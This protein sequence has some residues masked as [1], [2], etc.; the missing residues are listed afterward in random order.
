MRYAFIFALTTLVASLAYADENC[1]AEKK[2]GVCADELV[3]E[4]VEWACKELE[5]KGKDAFIS[6]NKMRYECC[7]EPNY[8]WIQDAGDAKANHI[9]MLM[10]PIKTQLSNTDVTHVK[11]PD[12]KE[13]F[14]EFAKAVKKTPSGAWVTYKWTKFGETAATPKKSWV[15]Q[16]KVANSKD[17]LI[18]G[19]GT[20]Q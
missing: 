9:M 8:V 5:S 14:V 7:G 3:K 17:S 12:N 15:K 6:V 20:W 16:C 2:L 11:D 18:A 10:H 4:R 19:S 1:T 13:L